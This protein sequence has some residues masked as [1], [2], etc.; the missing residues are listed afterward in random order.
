[1]LGRRHGGVDETWA[2]SR[3]LLFLLGA[4]MQYCR[5]HRVYR[6]L[7]FVDGINRFFAGNG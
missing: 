4:S 2:S 5:G 7:R 6:F 1:M 3:L